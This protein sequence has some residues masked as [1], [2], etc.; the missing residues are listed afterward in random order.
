MFIGV[1]IQ[2]NGKS[3]CEALFPRF[4]NSTHSLN[5]VP[6]ASTTTTRLFKL[7][8]LGTHI[9]AEM[10]ENGNVILHIYDNR[11]DFFYT[12]L[13][14]ENK[15]VRKTRLYLQSSRTDFLRKNYVDVICYVI[16][17]ECSVSIQPCKESMCCLLELKHKRQNYC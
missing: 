6:S 5:S 15:A 13:I 2:G 3:V 11:I 17:S 9:W 8:S 7:T 12:S 4:S 10:K 16:T 14:L 1:N